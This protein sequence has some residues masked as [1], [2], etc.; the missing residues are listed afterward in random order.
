MGRAKDEFFTD[1]MDNLFEDNDDV[2]S[3]TMIKD[4]NQ[5]DIIEE[6]DNL[7]EATS[8]KKKV[9]L[10]ELF[11]N[12]K[13]DNLKQC[14][15]CNST[16]N[17][18]KIPL[19]LF[20]NTY[21]GLDLCKRHAIELKLK[22]ITDLVGKGKSVINQYEYAEKIYY[23]Q[24]ESDNSHEAE[25]LFDVLSSNIT[26]LAKPKA[27]IIF[28]QEH[29]D[30]IEEIEKTAS[31]GQNFFN[32]V[33]SSIFDSI[34]NKNSQRGFNPILLS[35]PPG[36]GKTRMS[37]L[38]ASALKIPFKQIQVGTLTS[39]FEFC[40]LAA[41]W[42]TPSLG[43]FTEALNGFDTHNGIV[44]LDE[45]DKV[46]ISSEHGSLFDSLYILL[47]QDTC[48]L[49]ENNLVKLPMH[50]SDILWIATANNLEAIPAPILSRFSVIHIDQFDHL[51]LRSLIDDFY[52]LNCRSWIKAGY[53]C[54][55]LDERIYSL[56]E[57]LS[58]REVKNIISIAV[59]KSAYE[60]RK[61]KLIQVSSEYFINDEM[62]NIV[63]SQMSKNSMLL[64]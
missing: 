16:D 39:S 1:D 52:Q 50:C 12:H 9:T 30:R 26:T 8:T 38:V 45:I 64:H 46:S 43:L 6:R 44:L 48:N 55:P 56:C 42:R 2:T 49:F 14:E 21:Q 35:G 28:T 11:N 17:V 62:V 54:K 58:V 32:H 59:K 60:N 51:Q 25:K 22:N 34:H 63:F 31:N 23:A 10:D 36:V 18:H 33:K 37:N 57:K 27:D 29:I 7:E 24:V 47:E 53:R 41:T 40:G 4:L 19:F 13:H 61:S 5:T 3:E 15:V 20:N